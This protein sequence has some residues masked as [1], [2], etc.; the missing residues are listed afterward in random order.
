MLQNITTVQL[1]STDGRG[2]R[3]EALLDKASQ[4]L[5]PKQETT[6]TTKT[7]PVKVQDRPLV[8]HLGHDLPHHHD[9]FDRRQRE[10][11]PNTLPANDPFFFPGARITDLSAF[12]VRDRPIIKLGLSSNATF[13]AT[14]L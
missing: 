14:A 4:L 5:V 13:I 9:D 1:R 2:H 6:K 7:N 10:V 3:R 12:G 8:T 11:F